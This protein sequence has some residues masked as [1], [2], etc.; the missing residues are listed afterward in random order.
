MAPGMVRV[1]EDQNEAWRRFAT[2]N[3]L[4]GSEFCVGQNYLAVCASATGDYSEQAQEAA[5][6]IRP[7]LPPRMA[8]LYD[9]PER[10]TRVP[11]DLDTLKNLIRER[12]RT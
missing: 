6:G 7:P 9:R 2:A 12:I 11:N 1:M 8:G 5:T 4:P 3:V 10:V